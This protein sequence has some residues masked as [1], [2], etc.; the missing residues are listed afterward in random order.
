MFHDLKTTL[1][2]ICTAS[3]VF[4]IGF[5]QSP[6]VIETPQPSPSDLPFV[7][8]YAG[9][10]EAVLDPAEATQ[11]NLASPAFG[12]ETVGLPQV[13]E[14]SAAEILELI[15]RE[16]AQ[17]K[18]LDSPWWQTETSQPIS[19]YSKPIH[20]TVDDFIQLALMNSA[21]LKVA[22][23]L[24][25]IRKTAVTEA[26]AAFDWSTFAN[27]MWRDSSDPVGSSLT[28]GGT[29]T[30]FRDHDLDA[31]LGFRRR[32]Y[33]GGN[34]ELLNEL[35]YQENNSDFFIPN[36]Q[37][38]SRLVLRYTQPIWQGRGQTYNR[39]LIVLAAIDVQAAGN[40][41][42]RQLQSHLLEVSRSYWGLYLE[43]AN[44]A[45]RIRLYRRTDDLVDV[46]SGR[47][48][49]DAARSQEAR[50]LAALESRKSDLIRARAAV[51]NAETRLRAL[52]NAPEL[53]GPPEAIEFIPGDHP[54]THYT[55]VELESEYQT[56]LHNRPEIR[57]AINSI[58]A[59]SVRLNMAR[60]EI[61]PTL[62][63]ITE[64]YVAGLRGETD[65][66]NAWLDQFRRGEP[67]YSAGLEFDIPNGR[68]APR[69]R[70]TRRQLEVAQLQQE[71]RNVLELT[72][73]E[74]EIAV[75]E[76]ETSHREM[77]ARHR[78]LQAAELE[79]ETI[80]S[81]WR[82]LP[83]RDSDTGLL[84]DSL[85]RAQERVTLAEYEFAKAQLTYNLAIIN[86]RHS[87]G[88]LFQTF[89][90]EIYGANDVP[91]LIEGPT[92]MLP[93]NTGDS[94]TSSFSDYPG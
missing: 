9:I 10:P 51:K 40:E 29:G 76:L 13:H 23:F 91:G 71:Y 17:Q 85:L 61:L 32:L 28:V 90:N 41:Y 57:A 45:Q 20:T 89:P 53:A 58:R 86:L 68:R 67:S 19:R 39:S 6:A 94:T 69:A 26:Q 75:R 37:A 1:A 31:S 7:V 82:N 55:P 3:C 18:L 62:N 66:G 24:P 87:N 2:L 35:G 34:V 43:R 5:A 63:L 47:V 12:G 93:L 4:Q 21:K 52:I 84:L 81:R 36:D 50:A 25:N 49:L 77:I 22:D 14:S 46:I 38:T 48:G 42:A 73:A 15:G 56:A 80:A 79:A 70:L 59:A 54:I 92:E 64:A 16:N 8:P 88:T 65:F 33:S 83:Q 72:R 74:V 60:N 78:S 27:T 30:R 11:S 44:L